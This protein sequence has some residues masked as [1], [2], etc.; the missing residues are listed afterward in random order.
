MKMYLTMLKIEKG[1]ESVPLSGS[2]EKLMW[3]ILEQAT[4]S[5]QAWK[6]VL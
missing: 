5:I 1:S 2:I 3:S 4:S 6:S